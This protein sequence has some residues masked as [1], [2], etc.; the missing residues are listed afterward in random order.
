MLTASEL[1]IT[2]VNDAMTQFLLRFFFF[3]SD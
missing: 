1:V 2:T 3:M